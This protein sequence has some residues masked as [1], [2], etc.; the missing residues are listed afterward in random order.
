MKF[1]DK[2]IEHCGKQIQKL[3]VLAPLYSNFM[4]SADLL[5]LQK[6]F[7]DPSYAS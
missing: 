5:L 7:L 3:D 2:L 6:R 4:V 1:K